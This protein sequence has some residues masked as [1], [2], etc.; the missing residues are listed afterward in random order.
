[1][2]VKKLRTKHAPKVANPRVAII[3]GWNTYAPC[4]GKDMVATLEGVVKNYNV[5]TKADRRAAAMDRNAGF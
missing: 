2:K 5:Q 1:M 3:Q 4:T